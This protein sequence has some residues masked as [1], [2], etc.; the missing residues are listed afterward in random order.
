M[1]EARVLI[2]CTDQKGLVYNISKV[3]YEMELNIDKNGEY[4]DSENNKFFM[5][6]KVSGN[7]EL[8]TLQEAL[9]KVVP[10]DA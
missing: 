10:H 3:F 1:K 8:A 6:S 7:F 9:S 4:V 5:R 2:D